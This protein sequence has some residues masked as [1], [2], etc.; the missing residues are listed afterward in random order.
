MSDPL[1]AVERDFYEQRRRKWRRNAFLRGAGV[2]AVLGLLI[3]AASRGGEAQRPHI[4]ELAITGTILEDPRRDRLFRAIEENDSAL[5]L[6]LRIDS[7]G[8][9]AVGS[10]SI[11]VQAR[12]LAEQ[13]E[14]PVVAVMGEAAASGGYISA[15]AAD[16]IIARG[17]TI[18][19]SVGVIFEYPNVTSI[20]EQLGV[21]IETTR[22]SEL[23]AEP[24]PYR[25]TS[26]EAQAV[27]D[28]LVAETFGWFR[29][30]VGQ[31]RG[32]E[33]AELDAVVTGRIFTGRQALENGL[34]DQLGGRA[35]AIAWLEERDPDLEDLKV[36]TYEVEEEGGLRGLV[37][38]TLELPDFRAITAPRLLSVFGSSAPLE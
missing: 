36:L 31:R 11:Y 16:H 7:G 5:A 12:R 6:I 10:E 35:E 14:I 24:S 27:V 34:V 18:T 25:D 21:E 13:K 32:L 30:L 37:R 3:Y 26:P 38:S 22:S 20:V 15:L 28:E 2:A 8:G 1:S 33:G 4:A 19:G 9:S 17:N 23:K 29:D